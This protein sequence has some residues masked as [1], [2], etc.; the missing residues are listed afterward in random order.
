MRVNPMRRRIFKP[1]FAALASLGLLSGCISFGAEP[2][3]QLL[4]LTPMASVP[5][6]AATEGQATAA[7]AVQVPDVSQRLNVNRIPVVTSDSSLAYLADAFWVEKPAQLFRNVLAETIRAKGNRLVASGG[8][9][10]YV[11]QTQLAGTLAAMDYDAVTGSV[12]VRYD[13]VLE[14]PDGRVLTRRFEESVSGIAPEANA[15]GAALNQAANTVADQVA[16]WVG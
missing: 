5:A 2:P 3:E 15:V 14:L 6:G 7:L 13:A 12:V 11:A 1:A 9:L 8:E 10:E 16:E 4:T